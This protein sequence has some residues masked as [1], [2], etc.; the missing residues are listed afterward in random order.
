MAIIKTEQTTPSTPSAGKWKLYFK[1]DG[2]YI[3]DDTGAETG[4]FGTGSGSFATN[5]EAITGTDTT[6]T[7][8]AA[9]LRAVLAT[10]PRGTMFNLRINVTVS[11]NDLVVALK[12]HAGTDP[13]ATDPGYIRIGNTVRAVTA[14]TSMTLADATNW[15]NAG[16]AE[17]ATKEIDYFAYVVWDSNSSVVAVSAAR[18]PYGNLV[19]DFSGT[20]TNEKHLGNH[21]NFTSTD[22]VE[23]IG[24]FA[25]T[26]S[27]AAGHVWTV[28]AF[29]A[30]NLIQRP[31]WK[32]RWLLW[33]PD[34]PTITAMT[35]TG[36]TIVTAKYRVDGDELRYQ[37]RLTAFTIGGTP[38]ATIGCTLPFEAANDAQVTGAML[39]VDAGGGGFGGCR[40]NGATPDQLYWI[41][42]GLA[43][44]ASGAGSALNGTGFYE[45]L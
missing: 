21:A 22:E 42:D 27:A 26:L 36:E 37:V 17:L 5:A 3:I 10:L 2:L 33:T 39:W 43:S 8:N 34:F 30:I 35:V 41:K 11:S 38:N 28:P 32:T 14:A 19:S 25:A 15:F 13:S 4:P 18:I 1:T 24:R 45:M 40:I 31:I 6:K 44:W 12:T 20:T 23:V 9:N 7:L 16:G 29:T